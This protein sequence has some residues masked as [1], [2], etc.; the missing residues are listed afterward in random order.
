MSKHTNQKRDSFLSSIPTASI[1]NKN[2]TITTKCKFNFAYMDFGQEAGQRFSDWGKKNLEE[3]FEKLHHYSKDSLKY[4]ET[5]R[6]GSGSNTV[7]EIY[8]TFPT[9]K[10]DFKFPRNI[11]HQA[12]WGRFRLEGRARLIGFVIP[13]EYDKKL[14]KNTQTFFDCNTFYVVFLDANHRFYKT[15]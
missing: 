15:S 2:D 8:G 3:L 6:L 12:M 11:P 7:L 14:H 5:K 1:E 13:Q 10:S 9:N 4:W